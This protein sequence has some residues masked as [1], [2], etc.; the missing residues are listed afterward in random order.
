MGGSWSW[1][2]EGAT[3][4][5]RVQRKKTRSWCQSQSCE[6]YIRLHFDIAQCIC[7]APNTR[8]PDA[9]GSAKR[10]KRAHADT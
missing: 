3:G 9:L 7:Y 4:C 2:V 1:Q 10:L 8:V 6:F 5:S